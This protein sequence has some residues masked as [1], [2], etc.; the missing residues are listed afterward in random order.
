MDSRP[1]L[2]G[3]RLPLAF[4]PW[5]EMIARSCA[6]PWRLIFAGGNLA[7]VTLNEG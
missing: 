2:R 7:A 4:P 1:N 3:C 6:L 5:T